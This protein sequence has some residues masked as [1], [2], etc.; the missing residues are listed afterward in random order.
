M[1]D[2]TALAQFEAMDLGL[3]PVNGIV[4]PP[5]YPPEGKPHRHT[6]CLDFVLKVILKTI[7][8]HNFAWP[9][10]TPVDAV[11]LKLPVPNFL[12]LQI[13]LI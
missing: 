10:R 13:F 7:S 12:L 2:K 4:Q 6:N 3:E 11:K 8:K 1:K 9:F 5:V